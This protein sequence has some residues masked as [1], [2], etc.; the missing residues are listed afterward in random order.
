MEKSASVATRTPI[1]RDRLLRL[2]RNA[3]V[4]GRNG[5]IVKLARLTIP[6]VPCDIGGGFCGAGDRI[7]IYKYTSVI[8]P[9][10]PPRW[11]QISACAVDSSARLFFGTEQISLGSLT[12]EYCARYCATYYYSVAGVEYGRECWCGGGIKIGELV[13]R[14]ASECAMPCPEPNPGLT[15]G[16]PDRIQVYGEA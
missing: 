6:A 1:P 14:P 13:E 5:A 11:K 15:C 2:F 10:L 7:Q 12:P 9:V 16:G 3:T 4:S 8:K